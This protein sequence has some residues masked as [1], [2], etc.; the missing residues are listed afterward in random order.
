MN[1][2][3]TEDGKAGAIVVSRESEVINIDRVHHEI[4]EGCMYDFH[5]ED[6]D[7]D[8]AENL[9]TLIVTGSKEAHITIDAEASGGRVAAFIY[10][11]V[12]VS[13][14]GTEIVARNRNQNFPDAA[15]TKIY[16]GPTVTSIGTELVKRQILA[17][18]QGVAKISSAIRPSAERVLKPNTKYLLRQTST[19][20]NI[21]VTIDAIFYEE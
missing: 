7:L 6:L 4:H 12:T 11:D 1:T 14:N 9:D 8:N 17:S 13:A 18:S 3:V 10:R 19:A 2:T 15:V 5:T 20:D 21:I 16:A